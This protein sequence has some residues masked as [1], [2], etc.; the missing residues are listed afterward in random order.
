M[1][2]Y[3]SEVLTNPDIAIPNKFSLPDQNED[4][5]T[6]NVPE[7]YYEKAKLFEDKTMLCKMAFMKPE[8]TLYHIQNVIKIL[9]EQYLHIQIFP[10]IKFLKAFSKMVIEDPRLTVLSDFQ[11]ARLMLNLGLKK[12]GLKIR[13]DINSTG[14]LELTETE[15][16]VSFEKIKGLRDPKDDLISREVPFEATGEREPFVLEAVR[17]HEIWIELSI[18]LR[19][20]GEFL[21][22]KQ[23]ALEAN[24]H[25][26]ILKDRHNYARSLHVLAQLSKLEG[27]VHSAIKSDMYV[28]TYAQ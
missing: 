12:E 27:E 23:F 17:P 4:W 5:I 8:L 22:S 2:N 10:M 20:W 3:F 13:E 15:K 24:I 21:K 1:S 6:F 14:L 19:K 9:E 26:R 11:N 25:A 16:K 7:E 28:H 18:E